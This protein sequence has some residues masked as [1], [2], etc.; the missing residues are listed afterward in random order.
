[1]ERWLRATGTLHVTRRAI[2]R[3]E[4][5]GLQ[6]LTS[7]KQLTHGGAWPP[8]RQGNLVMLHTGRSG[9]SV[10]ADLLNQHPAIHWDGEL[11]NHQLTLWRNKPRDRM[12]EAQ[13]LIK[14]R[15][16]YFNVRFYG[17]EVLPTHL[18]AGQIEKDAFIAVL[19]DFDIEYFVLL[20]RRNILR[21][22][23][24]NL[25]ARK[26]GRWR[27]MSG[28]TAPLTRIHVD[29]LELQMAS[30]KPLIEHLQDMQ[31]E[32]ETLQALLSPRRCL[33]LVYEDDVLPDPRCAYR[34]ICRFLGV[35][36]VELPVRHGQTTPQPLSRIIQNYAE[37]EQ[38]LAGT[39]FAWMLENG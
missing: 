30:I 14:R 21:K 24:S 17:F 25:V 5:A 39:Q 15:I 1:M 16:N 34:K 12:I 4:T 22:I 7:W 3:V 18:Q 10:I 33:H 26:R 11:F 8:R 35:E 20:T 36:Y 13:G 2:Q 37:V 38:V 32:Y 27:L 23:I 28:E 31:A 19:E 9:S 6:L 29:T